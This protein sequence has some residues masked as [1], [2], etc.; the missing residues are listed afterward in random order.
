M[1][2]RI[3]ELLSQYGP[4]IPIAIVLLVAGVGLLLRYKVVGWKLVLGIVVSFYGVIVAVNVIMA[5]S[6]VGTF[7]GLEVENGY[8]ASQEFDADR[9]AQLALGWD[10]NASLEDG[11]VRVDIVGANGS[12]AEVASIEGMI[13]RTTERGFDQDLVFSTN[14][15]GA[16]VA[17][18]EPL[19][20]GK[21]ELRLAAVAADGTP[22]RQRIVLIVPES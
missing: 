22:F 6:A 10:V 15:T 20:V 8:I 3:I 4:L 16:H 2:A 7:P 21:W 19:G 12:A 18:I 9:T 11:D 13:G 17:P 1:N 5:Y 14:S